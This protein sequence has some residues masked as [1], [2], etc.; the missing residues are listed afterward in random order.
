MHKGEFVMVF[1]AFF[2]SLGLGVFI[3]LA[4]EFTVYTCYYY[5]LIFEICVNWF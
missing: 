1:I 3:G 5:K 2:A 4:G